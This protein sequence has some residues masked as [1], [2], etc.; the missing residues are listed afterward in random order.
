MSTEYDFEGEAARRND[1]RHQAAIAQ[2]EERA[3]WLWLSNSER[4]L[5]LARRLLREGGLL[6]PSYTG[7]SDTYFREG[8]RAIALWLVGRVRDH[9]PEKLPELF[10]EE[11]Q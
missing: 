7:N 3:D 5:R 2:R 4:G 6:E 11:P 9:A 1:A 10:R 8:K